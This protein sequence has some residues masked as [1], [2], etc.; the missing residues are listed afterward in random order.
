M[1][2]V[3]PAALPASVWDRA[4]GCAVNYLRLTKPGSVALLLV[5]ALGGMVVARPELPPW[6]L[7]AL[8][9]LG[10]A[11]AAGGANTL[12][13]Y[14]DRDLDRLMPRTS[15]R[16]LPSGRIQPPR[17]LAFGL[18]LC[19][20]SV[21]VL[22]AGVNPLSALLAALGVFYYVVVYTL[23]LKRSTPWNIVIGGG[24]GVMPLLVGSAATTGQL[25]PW[26]LWLG[27]VILLWTP[28]HFWSLALFR[29][30]EYALVAVPMLPVV[31]GEGETRRQILVYTLLLLLV[32][33]LLVPAGFAGPAFLG[34]ALLL[35]GWLVFQALVLLQLATPEAARQLYRYSI[36]YLALLFGTLI[37]ERL[38]Q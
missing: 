38:V 9:M 2:N 15:R 14:L 16:P 34:T 11:L 24:A 17:A 18:L 22:A 27:A 8:T 10:G 4:R 33:T 23:W 31:R 36:L 3:P 19:L 13:C 12:N 5:T 37:I 7:L 25:S 26:A 6:S 35:G 32:T 29:R 28:P 21:T 1:W 30:R 20:L